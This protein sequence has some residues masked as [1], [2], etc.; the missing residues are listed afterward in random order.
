MCPTGQLHTCRFAISV[1]LAG[2]R[3]VAGVTR[4]KVSICR[5]HVAG[6]CWGP[7]LLVCV[8][9]QH[10]VCTQVFRYRVQHQT[11]H[12]GVSDER[13]A[14]WDG[15]L[16]DRACV[17]CHSGPGS[18]AC[19]KI[20][21]SSTSTKKCCHIWLASAPAKATA[22]ANKHQVQQLHIKTTHTAA[23]AIFSHK[24]HN[25]HDQNQGCAGAA[26]PH[27]TRAWVHWGK[28]ECAAGV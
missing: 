26:P 23:A 20:A 2:F 3:G 28:Q 1:Y 24:T 6:L 12:K 16:V 11:H 22:T 27:E 25:S 5:F 17:S 13:E 7:T 14:G 18:H 15:S 10:Y 19:V 9:L 8:I 4:E 21:G